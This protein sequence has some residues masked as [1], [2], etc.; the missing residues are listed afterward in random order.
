MTI[1]PRNLTIKA[2]KMPSFAASN[3]SPKWRILRNF[4]HAYR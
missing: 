1:A 4:V 3:V 2:Q